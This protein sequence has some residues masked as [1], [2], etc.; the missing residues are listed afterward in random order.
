MSK[1]SLIALAVD[2]D[3]Y[4]WRVFD[5]GTWSMCPVN[6]DNSPI[7]TPVT[8]YVRRDSGAWARACT[9][10]AALGSALAEFENAR[11]SLSE[12]GHQ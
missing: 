5:D 12:G 1:S 6:A 10:A 9:A 11:S 8:F 4:C 2:A 3:G 7:P